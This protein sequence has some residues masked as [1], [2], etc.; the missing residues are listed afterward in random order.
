MARFVYRLQKVYDLRER[1]KKEQERRV[2]AAMERVVQIENAI[3]NKKTE[4]RTVRDNMFQA[5]ISLLEAHDIFIKKL[6]DDLDQLKQDLVFA[7]EQ[8]AY[9]K[10]MLLKATMDLE[11]LIKHKDK[12]YEEYLEEEKVIEM[13]MLDEVAGQRYFRAQQELI[14]EELQELLRLEERALLE[15][16]AQ[17][18][19]NESDDEAEDDDNE[20]LE[21]A[22][23]TY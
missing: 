21:D 2:A 1:R 4:I 7:N 8:L 19:G 6:N 11:A 14:E 13:R 23:L 12:C 3:R 18:L 5:P 17:E 16:Q 9:E 22:S 15:S 20:S 10:Q